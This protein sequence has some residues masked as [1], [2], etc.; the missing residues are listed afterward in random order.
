MTK[1]KKFT[2]AC[3]IIFGISVVSGLVMLPFCINDLMDTYNEIVSENLEYTYNKITLKKG[4]KKLHLYNPCSIEVRKSSDN[5]IHIETLNAGMV[6]Y[7]AEEHYFDDEEKAEV[8]LYQNQSGAI[9]RDNIVKLI[10]WN[11][12][13]VPDAIIYVPEDVIITTAFQ[14][15]RNPYTG[16]MY[17]TKLITDPNSS[18]DTENNSVDNE[19]NHSDKTSLILSINSCKNR[20]IALDYELS[21][22]RIDISNGTVYEGNLT[23]LYSDIY[24]SILEERLKI[25]EFVY[26]YNQNAEM[27]DKYNEI[28]YTLTANQQSVDMS[29]LKIA[30]AKVNYG[31][32]HYADVEREENEKIKANMKIIEDLEPKFDKYINLVSEKVIETEAS[33]EESVIPAVAPTEVKDEEKNNSSTEIVSASSDENLSSE[34]NSSKQEGSS[35]EASESSSDSSSEK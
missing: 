5:L 8:T 34:D 2:I 14:R 6:S 3:A 32:K 28:A 17:P 21:R 27:R 1:L 15:L 12:N 4:V 30:D 11:I 33:S 35:D 10:N 16:E 20:L 7:R 23:E 29:R 25:V 26:L 13:Y 19:S 31:G 24:N 18:T 9:T 22:I